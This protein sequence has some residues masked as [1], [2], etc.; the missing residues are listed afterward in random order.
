MQIKCVVENCE[1]N[2][3]QDVALGGLIRG[4][5]DFD[6]YLL[7]SPPFYWA[8]GGTL[9]A[10]GHPVVA[11]PL[12]LR[13]MVFQPKS[14]IASSLGSTWEALCSISFGEPAISRWPP[15]WTMCLSKTTFRPPP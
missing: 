3:A 11:N 4:T 12:I 6:G 7:A 5:G 10:P 15:G 2:C 13:Q 9:V 14:L 1:R 8:A